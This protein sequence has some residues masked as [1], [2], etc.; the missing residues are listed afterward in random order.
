[1]Q[2]FYPGNQT[3]PKWLKNGDANKHHF[4]AVPNGRR[5]KNFIPT[6]RLGDELITDQNRKEE[7]FFYVYQELLELLGRIRNR[8]FT[9][10]F[11][12]QCFFRGDYFHLPY[13][14]RDIEKK[15]LNSLGPLLFRISGAGLSCCF[16]LP[17]SYGNSNPGVNDEELPHYRR[18]CLKITIGQGD[19]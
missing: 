8:D 16:S 5:A 10:N 18:S 12:G 19:T 1:M 7:V 4:N 17:A 15:I 3:R 11:E 6:I 2:I 14:Y 13:S 9:L